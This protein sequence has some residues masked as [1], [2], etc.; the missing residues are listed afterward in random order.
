MTGNIKYAERT[1]KGFPVF[2]VEP[3]VSSV[4][5]YCTD[6]WSPS[7]LRTTS[8]V[9]EYL[10]PAALIRG[11]SRGPDALRY[12]VTRRIIDTGSDSEIAG[13]DDL[14]PLGLV[15]PNIVSSGTGAV[16]KDYCGT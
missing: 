5:S 13:E 3:G 14:D 2:E 4:S 12:P 15:K 7:R 6:E 10:G 16:S 11:W 1:Y 9:P 8:G